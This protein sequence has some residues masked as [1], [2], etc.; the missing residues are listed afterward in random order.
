MRFFLNH[1][2]LLLLFLILL[3]LLFLLHTPNTSSPT[4]HSIST[5]AVPSTHLPSSPI[6]S[7]T[8]IIPVRRHSTRQVVPSTKLNDFVNT[9][10]PHHN[11]SSISSSKSQSFAVNSSHITE[12]KYYNQAKKD[13][14]WISA[15]KKEIEALEANETWELT[16][17]PEGKKA[18]GSKWVYK[19]KLKPDGGIERHK[20]R[21]IAIGYQ[22][23]EGQDFTQTFSPVAKLATVRL[24]LPLLQLTNGLHVSLM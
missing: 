12:P 8:P 15:M 23:I 7:H 13:P 11:E 16:S 20:E 18:I 21:L 22:Q 2:N 1:L 19:T 3:L 24:L 14:N 5:P 10:V 9:Y 6:P 17:L 4:S